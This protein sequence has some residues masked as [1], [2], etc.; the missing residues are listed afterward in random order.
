MEPYFTQS[1]SYSFNEELE[2]ADVEYVQCDT[3]AVE[4]DQ[5]NNR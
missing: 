4:N 5:F 1:T 3:A 2:Q